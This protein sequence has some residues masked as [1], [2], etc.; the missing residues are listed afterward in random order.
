MNLLKLLFFFSTINSVKINVTLFNLYD[1]INKLLRKIPNAIKH[2][3]FRLFNVSI[4]IILMVHI[5]INKV[6]RNTCIQVKF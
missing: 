1:T 3:S 5:S 6:E 2:I 4:I